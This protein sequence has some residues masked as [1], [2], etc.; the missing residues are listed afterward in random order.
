MGKPTGGL[1][2][3]KYPAGDT[4]ATGIRGGGVCTVFFKPPPPHK[5]GLFICAVALLDA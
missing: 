3:E 4:E 2:W 5:M 1:K